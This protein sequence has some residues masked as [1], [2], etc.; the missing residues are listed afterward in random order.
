MNWPLWLLLRGKRINQ[1]TARSQVVRPVS[2]WGLGL[3]GVM[4]HLP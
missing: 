1:F 3:A 2:A 4:G